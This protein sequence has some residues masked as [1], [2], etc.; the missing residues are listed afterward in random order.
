MDEGRSSQPGF[1]I[2]TIDGRP[3]VSVV[4]TVPFDRPLS[5]GSEGDDVTRL[6]GLLKDEGFYEGERTGTFD[7]ATDAAVRAWQEQHAFP[8]DGVFLPG[9]VSLGAWPAVT[10]PILVSIGDVVAAGEP[11]AGLAA[12]GLSGRITALPGED[13]PEL[14]PGMLLSWE[15][16]DAPLVQFDDGSWGIGPFHGSASDVGVWEAAVALR[17]HS[18]Q[19]AVPTASIQRDGDGPYVEVVGTG[20]GMR[21]VAVQ[22]GLSDG[23][24]VQVTGDLQPG[25]TVV[26]ATAGK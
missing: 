21:R 5:T 8:V 1:K 23:D 19:L 14:R 12:P 18:N 6:Q 22:R 7:E 17:V 2:M 4:G 20:D 11:V 9:D 25:Q 10:A 15:T 16:G 24:Y 3:V 26:L 13:I